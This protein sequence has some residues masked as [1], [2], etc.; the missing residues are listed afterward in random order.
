MAEYDGLY[1]Y[2]KMLDQLEKDA[3]NAYRMRN[4][5][6]CN[7]FINRYRQLIAGITS[8]IGK[9]DKH[10]LDNMSFIFVE[11]LNEDYLYRN[12]SYK[13]RPKLYT[14]I[15][16]IG[17]LKAFL[18]GLSSSYEEDLKKLKNENEKLKNELRSLNTIIPNEVLIKV[19]SDIQK[20]INLATNSYNR[21]DY[22][23]TGF[24][25]R[26]IVDNSITI[27]C[28]MEKVENELR[29]PKDGKDYDLPK[30]IDIFSTKLGYINQKMARDLKRVKLFGDSAVHSMNIELNSQDIEDARAIVRLFLEEIF[31]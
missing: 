10:I 26:K 20:T 24:L 5:E 1:I 14:A 12:Y 29:N 8:E 2:L 11:A 31:P 27:K 17:Q 19:P 7:I 4:F 18:I 30:K 28:K 21:G 22:T 16:A 15:T 6:T 3:R 13:T 9:I 23:S 25:L